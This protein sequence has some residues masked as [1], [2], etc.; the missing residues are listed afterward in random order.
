[1]ALLNGLYVHAVSETIENSYTKT[2]NPV[3]EG[4][5]VTDHIERNLVKLKLEGE[6]ID[7]PTLTAGKMYSQLVLWANKGTLIEFR[8][9]NVFDGVITNVSKTSTAEISNGAKITIDFEEI[10]IANSLYTTPQ[11]NAGTQQVQSTTNTSKEVWHTV[12]K[13]EWLLKIARQYNTTLEWILANN[14]L[15]SG[16]PNLIYEGEKILV[17]KSGVP[18][19]SVASTN[20]TTTNKT[21]ATKQTKSTNQ[22]AKTVAKASANDVQSY[23]VAETPQKI[24]TSKL[25]EVQKQKAVLTTY[26]IP[27]NTASTILD[28]ISR[29]RVYV[30]HFKTTYPDRFLPY[31]TKYVGWVEY[32]LNVIEGNVNKNKYSTQVAQQLVSYCSGALDK[33]DKAKIKI[34][35]A[36]KVYE[37]EDTAKGL[38]E[39]QKATPYIKAASDLL[40]EYMNKTS[41]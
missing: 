1:M 39:A 13:G 26:K 29:M 4:V 19:T 10:R 30:K 41:Y 38:K 35:N 32:A 18:N 34:D 7:T 15:K 37:Q 21:T 40:H 25:V 27:N 16:N 33:C 6:L 22:T 12:K 9:R 3:E 31:Y 20:K 36:V 17:S 14:K 23:V 24:D 11:A 28:K 8:G 2:N 5:D